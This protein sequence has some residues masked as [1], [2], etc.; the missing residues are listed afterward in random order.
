MPLNKVHARY[1]I[2]LF[3][4]LAVF[5]FLGHI[6]YQNLSVFQALSFQKVALESFIALCL[7]LLLQFLLVYAWDVLLQEKQ[8]DY[9]AGALLRCYFLPALGKYLP[10]KV[11]FVLGRIELLRKLGVSRSE[12][13][14]LFALETASLII[15][16]AFVSSLLLI[17]FS[18]VE[19]YSGYISF[20]AVA[21]IVILVCVWTLRKTRLANGEKALD[22]DNKLSRAVDFLMLNPVAVI[23]LL[24]NHL[25][26]WLMYGLAG[27]LLSSAFIDIQSLSVLG[28]LGI[29]SAFVAAWL[30]GMLAVFTPGGLGVREGSLVI[31]LSPFMGEAE[32]SVLAIL[33]RLIWT[34]AELSFVLVASV[35]DD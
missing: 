25:L 31:C 4:V 29:G 34:F 14:L 6:I 17:S 26:L 23:K 33:M 12:A 32:A 21:G 20:L 2:S 18:G 19:G 16:A 7:C 3:C 35:L 1:F 22:K 9:S 5:I 11:L 24:A 8:L 13:S 27:I 30:F 28:Q 15:V 10:G